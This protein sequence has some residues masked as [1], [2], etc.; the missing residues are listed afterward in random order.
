M[1]CASGSE[2]W[3]V[4]IT[5][6]STGEYNHSLVYTSNG[7]VN[8]AEEICNIDKDE[9]EVIES[10]G[11]GRMPTDDSDLERRA[12]FLELVPGS[13]KYTA[14]LPIMAHPAAG[15]QG[16][17]VSC[18]KA[19][20]EIS[21]RWTPEVIWKVEKDD[22]QTFCFIKTQQAKQSEVL[23][24]ALLLSLP[25]NCAGACSTIDEC[26]EERKDE[27]Y[28]SCPDGPIVSG[29]NTK[30]IV[31][32]AVTSVLATFLLLLIIMAVICSVAVGLLTKR[33]RELYP[34]KKLKSPKVTMN[35]D[36]NDERDP[37]AA[38]DDNVQVYIQ[39]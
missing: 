38:D 10:S 1:L 34:S 20:N 8:K 14:K 30:N 13:I 3:S 31:F 7:E 33:Y 21:A 15:S 16:I 4:T 2:E 25:D 24:E 5:L 23:Q 29:E 28:Y 17:I 11:S 19:V 12:I 39:D 22:E 18:I 37:E 32:V 6:D 36:W 35:R 9:P 26:C 27:I